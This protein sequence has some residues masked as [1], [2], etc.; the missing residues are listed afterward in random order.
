MSLTRAILIVSWCLVLATVHGMMAALLGYFLPRSTSMA[1]AHRIY[2]MILASV[3]AVSAVLALA[4]I[5]YV[6]ALWGMIAITF[7]SAALFLYGVLVDALPFS[8]LVCGLLLCQIVFS[9]FAIGLNAVDKS[10]R[11]RIN[12]S[13][14]F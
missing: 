7:C 3:S 12:P 1:E 6:E 9:R 8:F 14:E 13:E 10:A 5:I 2:F 11:L 4:A